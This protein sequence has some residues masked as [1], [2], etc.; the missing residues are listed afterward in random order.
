MIQ[1]QLELI[2]P[3]SASLR[4]PAVQRVA[5]AGLILFGELLCWALVLVAVA[6]CIF[7]NKL[8]PFY[9]LFELSRPEHTQELGMQHVQMLRWSVYALI[10]LAAILFAILARTLAR[11]RQKNNVLHLAGSRIKNLVGQHLVRKAAIEALEQK[12]FHELPPEAL[13][14]ARDANEVLNPGYDPLDR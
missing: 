10:I 6:M 4:K 7:L 11:V 2:E 9:L 5:G 8:Y 1:S 13:P 3:L 14:P 12:H